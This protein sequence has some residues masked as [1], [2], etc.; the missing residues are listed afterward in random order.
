M[1]DGSPPQQSIVHVNGHDAV[2]TSIL[3]TGSGSTLAVVQGVK[4]NLADFEQ[5]LPPGLQDQH[6]KRPVA[7]R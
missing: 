7:V 1:H 3:K 6:A 5:A 4:N 2:L